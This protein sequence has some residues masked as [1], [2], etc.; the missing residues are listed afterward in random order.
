MNKRYSYVTSETQLGGAFECFRVAQRADLDQLFDHAGIQSP[1]FFPAIAHLQP[2]FDLLDS[3][4]EPRSGSPRTG[5]GTVI[6]M[7]KVLDVHG[8]L[9][10]EKCIVDRKPRPHGLLPLT[11][12]SVAIRRLEWPAS[13]IL[14]G[15]RLDGIASPLAVWCG[16]ICGA[17][18]IVLAIPRTG[19]GVL[20]ELEPI[21]RLRN[22]E[23]LFTANTPRP[24]PTVP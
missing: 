3:L 5:R 13:T 2:A 21:R 15:E 1:R 8:L 6:A 17:L 20:R 10:I 7:A 12:G 4:H 24:G 18:L 14:T 9:W 19:Q 23:W 16:V 22:R 11:H